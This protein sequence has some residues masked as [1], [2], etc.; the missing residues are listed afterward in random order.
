MALRYYPATPEHPQDSFADARESEDERLV[1]DHYDGKH[2]TRRVAD[3]P[4]CT[5]PTQG[6]IR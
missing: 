2:R 6:G 3:C 4:E 1:S 5:N